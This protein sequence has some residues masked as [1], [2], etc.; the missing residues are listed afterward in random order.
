MVSLLKETKFSDFEIHFLEI[1]GKW[2][3]EESKW[4]KK[5]SVDG[6]EEEVETRRSMRKWKRKESK[7]EGERREC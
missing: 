6:A 3:R 2:K 5:G 7:M 4:E 1:I